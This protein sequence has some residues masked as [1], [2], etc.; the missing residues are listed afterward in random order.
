MKTKKPKEKQNKNTEGSQY[1]HGRPKAEGGGGGGEGQPHKKQKPSY[2]Y[3]YKN[4]LRSGFLV[5]EQKG[6]KRRACGSSFLFYVHDALSVRGERFRLCGFVLSSS[7]QPRVSWSPRIPITRTRYAPTGYMK[8]PLFEDNHTKQNKKSERVF[9]ASSLRS[10][11]TCASDTEAKDE[12]SSTWR[13]F[14]RVVWGSETAFTKLRTYATQFVLFVRRRR[15]LS[16]QSDVF[17]CE[18]EKGESYDALAFSKTEIKTDGEHT[19]THKQSKATARVEEEV[20]WNQRG[21]HNHT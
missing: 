16:P 15:L 8:W 14:G 3:I 18:R 6:R 11:W 20:G 19:N 2:I 9:S 5:K 17:I 1:K 21:P 7:I 4:S 12:R 13:F 10:S